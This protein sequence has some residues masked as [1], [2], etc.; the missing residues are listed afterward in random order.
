MISNDQLTRFRR[1]GVFGFVKRTSITLPFIHLHD[2]LKASLFLRGESFLGDVIDNAEAVTHLVSNPCLVALS[3]A[4]CPISR[5]P[6][7]CLPT[8][9]LLCY[10][11]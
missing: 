5:H 6:L 7:F 9:G 2:S 3:L 10:H 4:L 8:M 1:F 11:E